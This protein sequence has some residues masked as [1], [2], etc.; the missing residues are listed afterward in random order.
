MPDYISND[1]TNFSNLSLYGSGLSANA[2][3]ADSRLTT[4][5]V[6]ASRISS[7]ISILAN[8]VWASVV[9]TPS[10]SVGGGS[11]PAISSTSALV[12]ALVIQ[13]SASTFTVLVWSAVQ[14]GDQILN[15]LG[16]G[17]TTVSSLS[18]G[19]VAH[20]HCTL[21]GQLEFRI[22]N[23]STLVQNQSSKSWYFT[24]IRPF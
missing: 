13:G 18:S 20:S 19:L 24:L 17:H 2:I 12:P 15:T 7:T 1:T 5:L 16:A 23:V 22:S 4:P 9:S 14:P 8:H 6:N 11:I 3:S 10:L 21:A